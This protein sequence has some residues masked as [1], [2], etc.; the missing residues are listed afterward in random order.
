M[1]IVNMPR[2]RVMSSIVSADNLDYIPKST[3]DRMMMIWSSTSVELSVWVRS[4]EL[5]SRPVE[6]VRVA[7]ISRRRNDKKRKSAAR[8]MELGKSKGGR[9][10]FRRGEDWDTDAG[11]RAGSSQDLCKPAGLY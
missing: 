9:G 10:S 3:D 2:T 1:S 6:L 4:S 8:E 7:M 5:E 11:R